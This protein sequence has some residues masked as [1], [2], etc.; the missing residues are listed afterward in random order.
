MSMKEIITRSVY[1]YK[2][3]NSFLNGT[4]IALD[5]FIIRPI[6]H[7]CLSFCSELMN[8]SLRHCATTFILFDQSTLPIVRIEAVRHRR[9]Q[10]LVRLSLKME[11]RNKSEWWVYAIECSRLSNMS[12]G[13]LMYLRISNRDRKLQCFQ[14]VNEFLRGWWWRR[15]DD[16]KGLL[17]SST[18]RV[19][20]S[21]SK[22]VNI[23]I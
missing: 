6:S 22:I 3:H 21:P 14:V 19:S 12:R 7:V 11:V 13:S 8:W 18:I 2:W 1:P 5:I 15:F 9:T 23:K 20:D 16:K 10:K 17:L 4:K